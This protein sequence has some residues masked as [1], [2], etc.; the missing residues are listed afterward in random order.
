MATKQEQVKMERQMEYITNQEQVKIE[1]Q[2]EY[3]MNQEQVKI[4]RQMEYIMDQEQVKI[5]RQMDETQ[6][7]WY[8]QKYVNMVS[9]VCPMASLV[10]T[11]SSQLTSDSQHL[12][13]LVKDHPVISV[14]PETCRCTPA[15]FTAECPDHDVISL[16]LTGECGCNCCIAYILKFL[17]SMFVSTLLAPRQFSHPG[18]NNNGKSPDR[19]LNKTRDASMLK[20][21]LSGSN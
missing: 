17:F 8:L 19:Y 3:T 5:E 21:P 18:I 9:T 4:E 16:L 7:L 10:L 12:D 13:T 1:R 6:L 11:D 14:V 2:M 20:A 15:G